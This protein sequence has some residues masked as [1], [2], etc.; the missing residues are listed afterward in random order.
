MNVRIALALVAASSVP[1]FAG[2]I[3]QPQ[4][5]QQFVAG[6]YFSYSCFEG[7][8]GTGRIQA[9]GSVAGTV[10]M[11]G[12]GAP[13]FVSLPAGTIR[14][15]PNAICASVRGMR[16]EPCFNVEKIDDNSFRGSI[17]G[18]GFAY[19]HFARR[20]PRLQLA[21]SGDAMG[22]SMTGSIRHHRSV[23]SAEA[24]D[25]QPEVSAT[26]PV[27]AVSK[28]PLEPVTEELT[29]RPSTSR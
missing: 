26:A 13:R 29:L 4:Q 14:V 6:K 10:R 20:N 5:A 28:A 27:A 8:T 24:I 19:C 21:Q 23:K 12:N 18:L 15:K 2:E 22:P 17:S 25:L 7:T 1:A 16:M 3:L 11:R 9:D